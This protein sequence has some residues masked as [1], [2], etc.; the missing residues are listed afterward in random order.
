MKKILI[1]TTAV[2]LSAT[3]LT[4][5]GN[6][7]PEE[8][9]KNFAYLI[10]EGKIEK[11]KNLSHDMDYTFEKIK[12]NCNYTEAQKLKNE[13]NQFLTSLQEL[14]KAKDA[15]KEKIAAIIND[16]DEEIKELKKE[17][18]AQSKAFREKYGSLRK[19]PKEE[20]DAYVKVHKMKMFNLCKATMVAQLNVIDK[21]YNEKV[22]DV[23]AQS[24]AN[25]ELKIKSYSP[26]EDAIEE[27]L[28]RN[29]VAVTKEC[30]SDSTEYGY[31]EDINYIETKELSPDKSNVRLELI[32][33]ND[34]SRK[35]TIQ[36]EKVQG[37][38]KV[39]SI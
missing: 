5:C 33:K 13:T 17:D 26:F 36:V 7:N 16:F 14:D 34:K 12:N 1:M 38:W 31:I 32:D 2:A 37:D 20:V 30:V 28:A 10:S 29:P 18:K 9:A 15:D 4:G 39:S 11:A 25:K 27:V 19:V 22:V 8:V 23:F 24:K 21:K 6:D 35:V 3:L